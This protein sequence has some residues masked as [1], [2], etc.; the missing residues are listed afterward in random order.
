METNSN[1]GVK[2]NRKRERK[3]PVKMIAKKKDSSLA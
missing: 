2:L 3:I 1:T